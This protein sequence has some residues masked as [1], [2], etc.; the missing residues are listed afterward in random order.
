MS[1]LA[2]AREQQRQMKREADRFA[3]T[4]ARALRRS[5]KAGLPEGIVAQG[6]P[7]EAGD[8]D[9]SELISI[10]QAWRTE[11]NETIDPA[12]LLFMRQGATDALNQLAIVAPVLFDDLRHP[13]AE[14]HIQQANN[15]LR[16]I[17]T[18]LWENTRDEIVTGVQ[19][20]ESIPQISARI[21]NELEVSTRRATTIARTEVISASNAGALAQM[22]SLAPEVKPVAKTWLAT[23]DSRTRPTH[24]AADGQNVIGL[25][26]NFTVGGASLEF[27]GDPH[28]PP[29]EIINCRCTILWITADEM[30]Q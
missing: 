20:G 26:T 2:K 10:E 12:L 16:G 22:E 11:L 24:R 30:E 21:Q 1:D 15:R 25:D 8:L 4:V 23:E 29:Q 18:S 28:G 9:I 5:I 17:G 14:N 19:Q 7:E 6:I 3:I 27:P 13:A